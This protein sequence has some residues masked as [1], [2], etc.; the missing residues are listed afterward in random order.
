MAVSITEIARLAGVST[1]SVSNYFNRPERVGAVTA[2]R[3]RAVVGRTG[4]V[5]DERRPGPK[6]GDRIG[7]RAG[8]VLLLAVGCGS[9]R[10]FLA[11]SGAVPFLDGVREGLRARGLS[12]LIDFASSANGLP[13]GFDSRKYDGLILFGGFAAPA[14]DRL[15][16]GRI[17]A[18]PAVRCFP[19]GGAFPEEIEQVI[20][21][22]GAAGGVAAGFLHRQGHR[23]VAVFNPDGGAPELVERADCFRRAAEAF[24]MEVVEFTVPPFRIIPPRLRGVRGRLLAEQFL[25][26]PAVPSGAFFCTDDSLAGVW[27]AMGG[28]MK[29][30]DPRH[31]VGCGADE[32]VL[33]LLDPVPATVDPDTAELGRRAVE[34]VTARLRGEQLAPPVPV[35]PR[36]L[37]GRFGV[38]ERAFAPRR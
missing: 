13:A 5:P 27:L 26:S 4:Y 29:S 8:C 22:N 21:D 32:W 11:Q 28:R 37:P 7:V 20:C 17:G 30:L 16:A 3:I 1:S 6:T 15:L 19:Y 35:R 36:L 9:L 34:R 31:L 12:L 23:L 33:S 25:R 2:A 18:F 14:A 38:S 10:E 24:R